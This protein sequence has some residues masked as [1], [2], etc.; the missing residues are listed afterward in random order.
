MRRTVVLWILLLI[1]AGAP[2]AMPAPSAAMAAAAAMADGTPQRLPAYQPRFGRSRP[3]VAIVGENHYTELTD[4]VVPY[5]ILAASGAAEVIALATQAGPIR[6]FPAPMNIEPQATTAAFDARYPQGADYVVVPAVHRDDDPVLL[7]W[8]AAQASKGATIVGVC[9]G[10]W[11]LARAGLLDGRQATGHWYS[12][13]DLRKKF[14]QADWRRNTRYVVDGRIVTT[15]GVT[16]TIPISLA[17]VEAIA[18]RERAAALAA[19]LGA[20]AGWSAEHPSER[21]QLSARHKLTVAGNVLS[22]WSHEDVGI[23]LEPGIDEIALV[24]QAEAYSATYRSKAYTV[25]AGAE[26]VVSKRGLRIIPDR[27]AGKTA[28]RRMLPPPDNARPLRA[29]DQALK[30][31]AAD[32]GPS[33]AAFV[34]LQMEYPG[35]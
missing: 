33:T 9:D 19:S 10:V 13:D 30:A 28:P 14:P 35:Y 11:V 12:F 17:L 25:A 29:L 24:L 5:G 32:Y 20:D 6:M 4:Y 34:A 15:T 18:G 1:G 21:F 2:S 16:A 7:A 31:I 26:A 23:A 22:F 27:V 3:V 8:V